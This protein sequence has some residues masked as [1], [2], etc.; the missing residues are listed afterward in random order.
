MSET[1]KPD[2]AQDEKAA[3]VDMEKKLKKVLKIGTSSIL[4]Q[5]KKNALTDLQGKIREMEENVGFVPCTT[6]FYKCK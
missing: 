1:L 4:V 6:K 5:E 3:L 2:P